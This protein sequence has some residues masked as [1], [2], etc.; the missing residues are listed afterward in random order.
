MSAAN[1]CT[2]FSYSSLESVKAA[3]ACTAYPKR[4]WIARTFRRLG[5]RGLIEGYIKREAVIAARFG[6]LTLQIGFWSERK[7]VT[8]KFALLSALALLITPVMAAAQAAQQTPPAKQQP[9]KSTDSASEIVCQ[10]FEATGSRI[11]VKRVCMTRSQWAD[12]QRLEQQEIQEAQTQPGC[13]KL[14]C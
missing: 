7:M 1:L 11:A 12:Q 14:R 4:A 8:H 6:L 13:T 5:W 10:K 9:G 2:E 3:C